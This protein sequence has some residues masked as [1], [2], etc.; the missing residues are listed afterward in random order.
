MSPTAPVE[1]EVV[2]KRAS[3]TLHEVAAAA[4]VSIATVSRALNGKDRV[5]SRTA[6]HVAEVAERL[7][8]RVNLIGRGLRAGTGATIGV[9]V[10][11]ISNPFYGELIHRLEDHLQRR[12]FDLVIADSHGDVERESDRLR[13]LVERRVEGVFVVPS[14]AELSFDAV[15]DTARRVP[16][17]QLDRHVLDLPADF[18][19]VDNDEGIELAVAHV[20]SRGAERVVLVSGNDVTSVGRERRAAFEATVRT[21]ALPQEVNVFGEYL[22]EFGESAVRTLL[23][24]GPLPD[25]IVAGDD[26]VAAGVIAALKRAGTRVPEDV[27]VTGF[28]GTMLADVCEP[29][30]TTVVQP[31][32]DLARE[33]TEA[34]VRRMDDPDSPYVLRRLAPSLRVAESTSPAP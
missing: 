18:I 34:L 32:D 2:V 4:G 15:A 12:G 10:P 3:V 13:M 21:R 6:E 28:D 26:L 8:Y 31:F 27:Q 9:V 19:G 33:A 23:A 24:R 20:V 25:A 29:R 30:L 17:V 11:V 16:L 14:D 5:S 1:I 22:L 7:G